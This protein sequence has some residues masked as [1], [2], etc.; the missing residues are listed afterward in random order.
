MLMKKFTLLIAFFLVAPLI[1][2]VFGGQFE[3]P[4]PPY[5]EGRMDPQINGWPLTPEEV[6]YLSKG[7][8]ERR[9]GT[10]NGKQQITY[11]PY[12][13]V[14]DGSGN[15]NWYVQAH[16]KLLASLDQFKAEHGP[17][18]DVL[19]VGD[20]ITWQWLDIRAP[21]NQYPQLFN[22]PWRES[23]PKIKAFTIG[24]AGDKS[25]GL[26]WRLDH[27]G[28]TGTQSPP[29]NPKVVV[30]AIGHNNMYFSRETGVDNAAKG[31]LWSAKNLRSKFPSCLIIVSKIF[32]NKT[33]ADAFYKDAQAINA[34]L[35]KLIPAEN[36]PKII[37]QPDLWSKMTN[38]DGTV[39]PE[40]FRADEPAHNKIHLSVEGYRLW[41]EALKPLIDSTI[42]KKKD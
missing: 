5:N 14:A 24:V 9:P 18:I 37:L 27:Q 4:Y 20:S 8:H 28:A 26:L 31:I 22:E 10:E 16:E 19:L 38:T 41:A 40:F 42:E 17:D 25:Q 3:Y 23:F 2:K 32:P 6:K 36:D 33:P 21:Y 7:A 30:L 12:T 1:P 11:L 35:D 29:L 15:P 34:E 13:P 39:R